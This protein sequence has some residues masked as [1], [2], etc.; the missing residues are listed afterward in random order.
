[1]SLILNVSNHSCYTLYYRLFTTCIY[2]I[3]PDSI[4]EY[5]LCPWKVGTDCERGRYP[6]YMKYGCCLEPTCEF[7][8]EGPTARYMQHMTHCHLV[9]TG[10]FIHTNAYIVCVLLVFVIALIS[11]ICNHL[12]YSIAV[13]RCSV[14]VVLL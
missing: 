10:R 6:K 14:C 8:A 7:R 3:C 12:C 1:M 4:C 2:S 11:V 9:T 13:C 5:S